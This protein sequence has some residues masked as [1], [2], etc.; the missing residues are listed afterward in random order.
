[1]RINNG[2]YI[3]SEVPAGKK[4]IMLK[5]WNNTEICENYYNAIAT[6]APEFTA[7]KHA[8]PDRAIFHVTA[9]IINPD[10]DI[11]LDNV[12][13]NL[14]VIDIDDQALNP[15]SPLYSEAL[16]HGTLK[17]RYELSLKLCDMLCG[18]AIG[19]KVQR[20]ISSKGFHIVCR[21][22]ETTQH[23]MNHKKVKLKPDICA[24][25]GITDAERAR[26]DIDILLMHQIKKQGLPL[27]PHATLNKDSE[28][29]ILPNVFDIVT[30]D[31]GAQLD[32]PYKVCVTK[33]TFT[34]TTY[35]V[36]KRYEYAPNAFLRFLQSENM[37][38]DRY[39]N[40]SCPFHAEKTPSC[41]I[42]FDK[43]VFYCFGCKQSGALTQFVAKLKGFS[44]KEAERYLKDL[45]LLM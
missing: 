32:N 26:A 42:S 18:E 28:W 6:T 24:K 43:N 10:R 3:F 17:A 4:G 11:T 44:I 29:L 2:F 40:I 30:T 1:M 33:C 39:N 45:G 23:L 19:E 20:Y 8:F 12:T 35:I 14:C 7:L 9:Q 38:P 36:H 16:D 41:N 15:K 21:F 13:N 5:N 31:Q 25:Y 27:K 37:T 22:D 34:Q